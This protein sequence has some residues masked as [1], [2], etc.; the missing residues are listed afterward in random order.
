[1]ASPPNHNNYSFPGGAR[2]PPHLPSLTTSS[3]SKKRAAD[4][5]G[6]PSPNMKRRKGSVMSIGSAHP[7]RQ[8]SFP[9][10]E[11]PGGGGARSPSVDMDAMS[12]VSGTGQSVVSAAASAA[13]TAAVPTGPP[14]KKRGRKSKAEKAREQTPSLAGGAGA[15]GKP[16][17]APPSEVGGSTVG[18]GAKSAAAGGKDG[19]GQQEDQDDDEG[20][21]EVAATADTLTKEEKEEEHRQRGMLI[22][23][24]SADQFDRFENW[25]AANLSKAG[26]RRLINATISQSVTENV[27]IGMRAVAKVFIGDIIEGARRVQAEWI[28]K[29]DE[30]QTDLP[31]PPATPHHAAAS[32]SNAASQ[33]PQTQGGD[34]QPN[35]ENKEGGDTAADK[36]D[37]NMPDASQKEKEKERDDR[38][39]PLR[40][41]HLREALRRYKMSFEGGGV[42][43]QL[44]WHQ[45]QQNGVERFPTRTGGRRIFR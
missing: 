29:T 24:F 13:P 44:I 43:M 45:Q 3:L 32:N 26:V 20:P 8:T 11:A 5:P 14:K 2:S 16:G 34:P 15:G 30:K 18:R 12:Y 36:S 1:M 35:G 6:G 37:E 39:G 19:Q 33:Q 31:S 27:V 41:E 25:R 23:A 10:D 42:G 22:N 28:E 17:T 4:G 38:R 7:L 9:P 40:P 21:T